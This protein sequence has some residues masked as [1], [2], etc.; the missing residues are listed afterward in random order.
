[1]ILDLTSNPER[2]FD[3]LKENYLQI[4]WFFAFTFSLLAL[5]APYTLDNDTVSIDGVDVEETGIKTLFSLGNGKSEDLKGKINIMKWSSGV[6]V[7]F[8]FFIFMAETIL[9]ASKVE[10]SSSTGN[11][12]L[13]FTFGVY[14]IA[15]LLATIP[16][17]IIGQNTQVLFEKEKLNEVLFS[18]PGPFSL[19]VLMILNWCITFYFLAFEGVAKKIFEA[20]GACFKKVKPNSH[21]VSGIY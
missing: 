7:G 15:S 11:L 20:F 19:F 12:S 16:I 18:A 13:Y 4:V 2:F 5:L 6:L 14:F 8:I 9:S 3:R 10:K 21:Y 17:G 1:M